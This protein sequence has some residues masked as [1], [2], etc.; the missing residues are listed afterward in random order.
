MRTFA[1]A[2][3]MAIGSLAVAGGQAAPEPPAPEWGRTA[4]VDT[5]LFSD[6]RQ[7]RRL[8]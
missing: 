7:V 2:P 8:L 4:L 1:L 3:A 6:L 5:E